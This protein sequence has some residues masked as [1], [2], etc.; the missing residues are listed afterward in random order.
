MIRKLFLLFA[1]GL[2][3]LGIY[4]QETLAYKSKLQTRL[5]FGTNIPITKLLQGTETDYLLQYDDNS[6]YWQIISI[7]YFFHKHWGL[8]FNYQAGTS[9]RIRQRGD[10]FM[11][12]VQSMYSENYFVRP[13]TGAIY[14]DNFFAGD[15]SR[16]YLGVIYRFETNKFYVYPKFAIGL[17]SIFTSWGSADL[18]EKNS[19]NEHTISYLNKN[20]RNTGALANATDFFTFAPSI[21]LGYKITKRFYFNADIMFSHFKTNIVYEKTFKNLYTNE[22]TVEHFD[23]KKG[24]STLSLGAGLI[25]IIR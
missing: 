4:G 14:N 11:E 12:S 20:R 9:N 10:N 22:S 23:Y 21:S 16:G 6:F 18:K 2:F 15:I 17:T 3:S 7:S 25:F 8:E 19:N 13:R 5:L 24:V 1:F